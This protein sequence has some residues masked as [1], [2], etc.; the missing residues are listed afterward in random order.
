[1]EARLHGSAPLKMTWRDLFLIF[2]TLA[3]LDSTGCLIAKHWQAVG[4][5]YEKL[6]P[7]FVFDAFPLQNAWP[8]WYFALAS[9][10]LATVVALDTGPRAAVDDK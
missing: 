8:V 1:M 6:L 5:W 10:G 3:F 2:W 4:G 9:T 7:A